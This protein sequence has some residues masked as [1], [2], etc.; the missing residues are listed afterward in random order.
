MTG[1]L[2]Q[3]FKQDQQVIICRLGDGKEYRGKIVGISADYICDI[4]IVEPFD[5]LP[6]QTFT[7][8]TMTEACLDPV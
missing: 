7:H 8:I 4:Y 1:K 5:Q 3:N 6:G 2:K